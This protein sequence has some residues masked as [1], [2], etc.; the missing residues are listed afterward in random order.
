MRKRTTTPAGGRQP[1]PPA[2]YYYQPSVQPT[3][4]VR[5]RLD[6]MDEHEAVAYTEQLMERLRKKQAREKNYLDGRARRGIRRPTDELYEQDQILEDEILA[7][8]GEVIGAL[9]EKAKYYG[10]GN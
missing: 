1:N 10:T 5:K 2:S 6:E 3:L 9:Q 7:V 4:V 8:L